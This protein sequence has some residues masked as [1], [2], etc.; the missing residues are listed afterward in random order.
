MSLLLFALSQTFLFLFG[1]I[2]LGAGRTVGGM[3]FTDFSL[4]EWGSGIALIAIAGLFFVLGLLSMVA[5]YVLWSSAIG[6]GR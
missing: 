5:M 3:A 6:G 2:L 4:G 1:S